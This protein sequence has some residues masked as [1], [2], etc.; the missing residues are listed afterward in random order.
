MNSFQVRERL[1]EALKLDLVGPTDGVGA[2][3]EVLPQPP[4]RWYL[5]EGWIK[6]TF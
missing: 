1:V 4:S 5:T 3:D 6:G 2:I